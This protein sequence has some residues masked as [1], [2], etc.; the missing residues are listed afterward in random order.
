MLVWTACMVGTCSTTQ[1]AGSVPPVASSSPPGLSAIQWMPQLP[2]SL[3]GS[4]S[5]RR[6]GRGGSGTCVSSGQVRAGVRSG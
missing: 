5:W 1:S 4:S 6:A 3:S 2:N